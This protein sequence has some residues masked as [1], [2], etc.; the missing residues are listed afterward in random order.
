MGS[1]FWAQGIVSAKVPKEHG[2]DK[3][4]GLKESMSRGG[5]SGMRWAG[6]WDEMA[7]LGGHAEASQFYAMH[8]RNPLR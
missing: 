5:E 1:T 8:S 7:Y 6:D 4:K 3:F 2:F